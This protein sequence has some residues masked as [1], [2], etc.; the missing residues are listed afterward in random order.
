VEKHIEGKRNTEGNM[1]VFW[2]K[3]LGKEGGQALAEYHVLI[4]GSII[5]IWAA[6]LLSPALSDV[7]RHVVS[8]V[9]SP[10]ECVEF[11]GLEDNSLCSHHEYCQKAEWDG[12]DRGEFIYE[13]ALVVDTVVIKA[14][15]TYTIFR[16]D[17]SKVS[18]TTDDGCYKVTIKT[19][20][21]EWERIGEGRTCQEISHIDMWRAPICQ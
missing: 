10:L 12:M 1:V 20:R 2:R 17:P 5:M 14:G 6:Y 9:R 16:D 8:I 13:D 15:R 7:Y 11:N 18:Y 19:N 3:L 4:P 21:V